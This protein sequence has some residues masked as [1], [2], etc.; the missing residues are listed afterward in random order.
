M[1][2]K[3]TLKEAA[4]WENFK[5][6]MTKIQEDPHQS[7]GTRVEQLAEEKPNNIAL[8]F[9][10]QSWTWQAFNEESNKIAHHFLNLGLKPG[11]TI[12]LMMENSPEYLFITTGINKIQGISALINFNQKKQALTHSFNI[13]E[14]KWIIV[15]G[16]CLPSF[17]DSVKNLSLKNS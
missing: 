11:E 10:D 15:D 17:N 13:A 5:N 8:Y 3:Y 7:I 4:V 9:Q 12:A 1:S 2:P 14:P 6:F 16:D